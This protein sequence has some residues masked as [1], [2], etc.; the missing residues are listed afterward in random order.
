VPARHV[1]SLPLASSHRL[2]RRRGACP[3]RQRRGGQRRGRARQRHERG[4][5]AVQRRNLLGR[6]SCNSRMPSRHPLVTPSLCST[7][8][9][10]N[11]DT[12]HSPSANKASL[13][14]PILLVPLFQFSVFQCGLYLTAGGRSAECPGSPSTAQHDWSVSWQRTCS[15]PRLHAVLRGWVSG[16]PLRVEARGIWV[17]GCGFRV[18]GVGFGVVG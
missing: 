13:R 8:S 2:V 18:S 3:R 6:D 16:R 11:R 4:E 14:L 17:A 1:R 15:S 12:C 10:V 5:H 9:F 7:P